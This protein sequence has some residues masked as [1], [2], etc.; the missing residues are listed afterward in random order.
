[1][2]DKP[3]PIFPDTP[4]VVDLRTRVRAAMEREAV[5]W[6]GPARI[7]ERYMDEPLAVLATVA[8]IVVAKSIVA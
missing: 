1:M 8:I 6:V 3:I 2:N 7:D 4:R 5:P